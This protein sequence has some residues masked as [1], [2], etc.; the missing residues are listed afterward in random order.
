LN[1]RAKLD[2]PG[3]PRCLRASACLA[4]LVLLGAVAFARSHDELCADLLPSDTRDTLRTQFPDLYPQRVSDLSS[5]Y[6]EA[7]LKEHPQEC[8]GVAVGHFQ[9]LSKMSYAVLLV[10]SK[11]SLSGSKLVVMTQGPNGAWK[12]T[13]LSEET[14]AYHYEAVSKLSKTKSA[15]TLDRIRFKEFDGGASV[16]SFAGGRFHKTAVKE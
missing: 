5:E 6:Q 3:K 15:G 16:Y 10:G 2:V 8:P 7:W 13:K 9:S 11:G 12:V 4:V 14:M 1:S